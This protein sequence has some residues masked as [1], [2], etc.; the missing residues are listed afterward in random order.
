MA[1]YC[2]EVRK[3]KD[4]FDGLELNH[5]PC[6]LNEATNELV[7]MAS[8]R[9]PTPVGVFA[10]DQHQP[11]IRFEESGDDDNKPPTLGSGAGNGDKPP[12][13]GSEAGPPAG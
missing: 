6:R 5:I 3:L 9:E 4:K 11:S 13:L 10:C 12:A 1:A 8:G 2:H 7:K